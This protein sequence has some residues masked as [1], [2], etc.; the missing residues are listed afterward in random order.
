FA[1]TNLTLTISGGTVMLEGLSAVTLDFDTIH[2]TGNTVLDFGAS[3]ATILRSTN[4]II[5]RGVTV[6]VQNW[7]SY[8]DQWVALTAFYQHDTTDTNGA[9]DRREGLPESQ[10]IFNGYSSAWTT[11]VTPQGAF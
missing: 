5:D 7:S 11:W 9:L 10:I 3:T 8:I 6:T 1:A 4:L 2:I